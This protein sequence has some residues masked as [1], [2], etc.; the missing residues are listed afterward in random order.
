MSDSKALA[1]LAATACAQLLLADANALANA[2]ATAVATAVAVAEA[3]A[4]PLPDPAHEN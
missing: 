2:L 4:H 3:S 1:W